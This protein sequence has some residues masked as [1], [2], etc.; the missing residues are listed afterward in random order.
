MSTCLFHLQLVSTLHPGCI[1][2]ITHG[3]C[4]VTNEQ[5]FH[6]WTVMQTGKAHELQLRREADAA[7]PQKLAKRKHQINSLFHAAKLKV[8]PCRQARD[9]PARPSPH[10]PDNVWQSPGQ[11]SV[12]AASHLMPQR[13]S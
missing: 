12:W 5:T 8:S 6:S 2:A 11:L 10:M 1:E 9:E 4:L 7:E 3:K 13:H